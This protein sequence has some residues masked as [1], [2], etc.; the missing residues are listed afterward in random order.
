MAD[1]EPATDAELD[2]VREM[3]DRTRMELVM[4][5]HSYVPVA[6]L[7]AR[8]D[9]AEARGAWRSIDDEARSGDLVLLR[10]HNGCADYEYALVWW[11]PDRD[12]EYPWHGEYNSYPDLRFD[13]Y[14]PLPAPP[15]AGG[16][17]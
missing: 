6:R 2:A 7:L 13:E 10:R 5:D 14:Q 3:V 9:Q 15:R 11:R 8:L 1:V 17:P 4:R 16:E 12:P